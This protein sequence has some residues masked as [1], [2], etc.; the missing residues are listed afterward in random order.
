MNDDIEIS[1]VCAAYNHEKYIASALEG[2]L[3]QTTNFSVEILVNDDASTDRTAQIIKEYQ[4]RSGGRIRGIYQTENQ[5]SQGVNVFKDILIPETR[6]K[7]IAICEGD[8][9]WTDPWKLQKQYDAMELHP[10]IDLCA[11]AFEI[12]DA[13]T[14]ELVSHEILSSVEKVIETGEV[15][16]GEGG[17]FGTNTLM[18]RSSALFPMPKFA[19]FKFYDYSLQI[20]GALRGGVI[21][22]PDLMSV[23]RTA[24]PGSFCSKMRNNSDAMKSYIEDKK[25]MLSQLDEDTGRQYHREIEARVL[26]YEVDVDKSGKENRAIWKSHKEGYAVLHTKDKLAV[27]VKC[28]LPWVVR[29]K[30]KIIARGSIIS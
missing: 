19:Q 7:Y 14:G 20:L 16:L 13:R 15:I 29:V 1:I 23:Y 3:A 28:I 12:R 21:Y 25:A 10:E 17:F 6:G 4:R 9:Y 30:R 26:L 2:F 24:V 5:Y 18:V 11:H 27:V 8:D 22:L